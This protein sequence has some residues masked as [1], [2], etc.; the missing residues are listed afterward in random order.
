M[1]GNVHQLDPARMH[2]IN[3]RWAA[4]HGTVYKFRL[5]PTTLV[6]VSDPAL[7]ER[8]LR[9]RPDTYRR[10]P[11]IDDVFRELGTA[12]VFSA[13]GAEWR[14]QRR[15]AMHA[16]SHRNL[17]GFWPRLAE[18]TARLRTR[19]DAKAAAGATIDV[20]E[21][22]KRYTVDVTTLLVLGHDVDTIGRDDDAI[23][24]RL[25]EVFPAFNRRLLAVLPTWRWFRS[26]ADRRVDRAVAELRTWLAG[27]VAASRERLTREPWRAEHPENFLEAMLAARDDA[28]R[29]FD[30][31]VIF[32]NAMTML[33]AGEDTTAQTIAWA[34]HHLLDAPDAVARLREESAAALGTDGVPADIDAADGLAF[35]GAVAS[36]AMRLRPVAPVNVLAATRDVVLGDVELPAGTWIVVLMR[37][38]AVD[39]ARFAEPYEFRPARWLVPAEAGNRGPHDPSVVHPFGSGPRICPGRSLALL[40]MKL[41]LSMLYERFDVERVGD[42]AAVREHF[43]FTMGPEGLRA[44]LRRR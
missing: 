19:W 34:V 17:R 2:L 40:E 3:E 26:R 38:A 16:L 11:G 32:G 10:R 22:M 23:Q 8:V 5:G 24:R 13:E 14:A 4:E 36:E 21:E 44:R 27:L 1:L 41:V 33:L 31:E 39:S 12:G 18:V 20:S 42:G 6:V 30:D 29:P 7:V 9:D 25:G 37:P 35:A 15:L 43:A 28:G